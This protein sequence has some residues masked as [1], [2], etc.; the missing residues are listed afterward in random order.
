MNFTQPLIHFH[1][2]NGSVS[3]KNRK[4]LK[5]FISKIFAREKVILAE[6]HYIFCSDLFLLDLNKKY[7]NHNTYTDIITFTLSNADEPIVSDIYISTDRVKENAADLESSFTM[8]IHRVIF[9]GSLH[10]CGYSD[11]TKSETKEMREKEDYYLKQY[12]VS[13]EII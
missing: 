1:F 3:L 9:H 10:L 12:F 6:L 11:K 5:M 8:E 7:L 13:R 2:I 4:P